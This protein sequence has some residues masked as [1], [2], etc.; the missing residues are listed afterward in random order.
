MISEDEGK[1]WKGFLML[2][3]RTPVT[4]PDLSED[5]EG[6]IYITYDYH[7]FEDR[8]ILMAKV[9]EK[10]ILAGEIVTEGSYLNRLVNRATGVKWTD[11]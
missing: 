7:R 8:E 10:D 1:T 9:T 5:N 11:L 4:Y 2:D 3:D 6:N